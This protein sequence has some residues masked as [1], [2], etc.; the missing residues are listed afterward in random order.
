MRKSTMMSLVS[1]LNGETITNIDEIKQELEAELNR[2]AEKAQ[3][4]RDLYAV[5]LDVVL[6]GLE[7]CGRP[8]TAGELFDEIE[9]ELPDGFTKGKLQYALSRMWSD[10]V[11]CISGKPNTYSLAE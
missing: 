10:K 7:L 4:N 3:A 9:G 5:A 11:L 6:A 2:N 1:Y 8:V